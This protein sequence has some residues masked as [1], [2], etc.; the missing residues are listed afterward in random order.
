MESEKMTLDHLIRKEHQ[1]TRPEAL[2]DTIGKITYSLLVGAGLDYFQAGLRGWSIAAART[3]ATAINFFTGSPYAR[4]REGWYQFT[5]THEK[6]SKLR[7][8]LIELCAFNTFETYVYGISAGIGSL[9]LTGT[10]D[11]KKIAD[12]MAGLL[13]LSPLI[14]PT[15]G[16]WLNAT[17]KLFHVRTVAERSYQNQP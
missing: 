17:C 7:Q 4:W 5:G 11:L 15:M 6:S 1:Y 2:A 16:L 10:L 8:G 13:Y 3:S 12:G 9:I 14:G